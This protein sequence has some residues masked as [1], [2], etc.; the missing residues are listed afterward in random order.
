MFSFHLTLSVIRSDSSLNYAIKTLR[1]PRLSEIAGE[2][3]YN[4]FM[5]NLD[6]YRLLYFKDGLNV[7]VSICAGH[8]G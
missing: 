1:H 7:Q 6:T 4:C 5:K 3:Q 8:D 2:F